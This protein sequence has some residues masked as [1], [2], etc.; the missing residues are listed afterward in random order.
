MSTTNRQL[1]TPLTIAFDE[2]LALTG[3]SRNTLYTL[4]K[5]GGVPG[6]R[7]LGN[8]WRFHRETLLEW[9]KGAPVPERSRTA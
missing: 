6:A 4:V 3:V 2:A 1:P 8:T 5:K 9:L 7:K